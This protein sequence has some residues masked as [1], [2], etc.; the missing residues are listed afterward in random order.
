MQI[1]QKTYKQLQHTKKQDKFKQLT[2][3]H[4]I[5]ITIMTIIVLSL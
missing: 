3:T 4:A 5:I 1:Y 2:W